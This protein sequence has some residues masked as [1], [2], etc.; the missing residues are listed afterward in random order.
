[1]G[2]WWFLQIHHGGVAVEGEGACAF[3][4]YIHQLALVAVGAF[5]EDDAIAPGAAGVTRGV[6]L[7]GTFNQNLDL[8]ADKAVILAGGDSVYEFQEPLI[9]FFTDCLRNLIGHFGGGSIAALGILEDVSV[10]EF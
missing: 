8:V 5:K 4:L 1:M 7:A 6:F 9:A 2:K 10:V 3:D